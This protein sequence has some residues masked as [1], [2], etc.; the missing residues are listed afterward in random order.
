M[1]RAAIAGVPNAERV[2]L[3]KRGK[4]AR[5]FWTAK[6]GRVGGSNLVLVKQKNR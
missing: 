5:L 3:V 4:I 1:R 6:P 2:A